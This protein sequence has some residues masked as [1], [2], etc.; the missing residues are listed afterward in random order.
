MAVSL[1]TITELLEQQEW[2]ACVSL[3]AR[4]FADS[5]RPA[6]ERAFLHF[7]QCRSLSNMDRYSDALQPGQLAAYLAEEVSDFD[8]LGR[9]LL[10]LAWMQHKIQGMERWAPETQRRFLS[11]FERFKAPE[12]RSRYLPSLF[13]LGVYL[14]ASGQYDAALD[15][16]KLTYTEA[17]KR[18]ENQ[19]AQLARST[20][21]WE[22]LRLERI[23]EAED[24]IKQGESGQ[25]PDPRLRASHLLDMAQLSLLK[26]NTQAAC[27]HALQASVLCNEAP[28]LLA[29][30]LEIL[31]RV[32]DREGE[33][34]VAM[35]AG[36]FAKLQAEIDDR[37]DIAAQAT[38]AVR[39]AALR[40]PEA[41]ERL[42][43][44]L[45]G[46]K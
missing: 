9:T 25:L 34:E 29:R 33:G 45:D 6:D 39:S 4:A 5:E 21:V 8:L 3:V 28:D 43:M 19:I 16:F 44:T 1:S 36:I 15:Q 2:S 38:G 20:A 46:T 18:G 27:E 17:K 37:H 13:N 32:A 14:R 23:A 30:G 24:L 31:G 11:L 35:V 40:Y 12:L 26:G 10:E 7:A 41:V 42:M 22:A